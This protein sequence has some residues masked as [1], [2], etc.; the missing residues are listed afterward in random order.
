MFLY[1]IVNVK[2]YETDPKV[3]IQ[4]KSSES[5]P[6]GGLITTLEIYNQLTKKDLTHGKKIAGTGTIEV[7]GTIGQ[8]GGI[9]HKIIGA[10]ADD[11]EYFLAPSGKN[12]E[13]AKAYIKENK[14]NIKLIEV[15]SIED[16]IKK[17]E[18]LK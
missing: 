10:E 13:E 17:L 16:A 1:T 15:K 5:G 14:L 6:S 18:V 9:K 11:A 2:E 4:F 12:Y 3:D 8:I 7:D